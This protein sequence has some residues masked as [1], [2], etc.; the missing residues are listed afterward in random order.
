MSSMLAQESKSKD[1]ETNH[2]KGREETESKVT[3]G[4]KEE[5]EDRGMANPTDRIKGKA[6]AT[7][8]A[9][10]TTVR[11]TNRI[12]IKEKEEKGEE[13]ITNTM[14]SKKTSEEEV[15]RR[16]NLVTNVL[17]RSLS[18]TTLTIEG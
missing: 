8:E 15:R 17:T 6:M 9:S 4:M 18:I 1:S 14:T 3:E 10:I 5:T 11:T 16:L 2:S 13:E 7:G 12:T